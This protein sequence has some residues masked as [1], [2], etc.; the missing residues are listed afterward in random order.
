MNLWQAIL[1]VLMFAIAAVVLYVWGMKKMLV[2]QEDMSRNLL[3]A[4]G[5]RVVKYL[6]KHHTISQAEIAKEIEGVTIHQ[7]WSRK[8]L[9]VQNGKDF[10]P[11][12][13]AFLLDQQYI[14]ETDSKKTYRLKP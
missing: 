3:H 5:S 9:T 6:K 1:G 14:Q 7:I 11:Q 12:V 8:R 13:I 10:A 4:C 2:Q